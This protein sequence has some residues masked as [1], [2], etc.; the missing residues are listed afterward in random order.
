M[1]F[2]Y[3]CKQKGFPSIDSMERIEVSS[4]IDM[5]FEGT[6]YYYADASGKFVR[7][8]EDR[9]EQLARIVSESTYDEIVNSVEGEYNIILHDKDA[10]VITV[11]GDKLAL[12]DIYY[13][14][15]DDCVILGN[16]LEIF[17]ESKLQL[18]YDQNAFITT[19]LICMPKKQTIYNEI[20]RL[21]YNKYIHLDLDSSEFK[22]GEFE[23]KDIN[24]AD[25]GPDDLDRYVEILENAILSRASDK[26][27]ILSSSGG[28]DSSMMLAILTKHL[29]ADKV[30]AVVFEVKLPDGTIFNKYEIDKVLKISEYL[31]V[32]T[33]ILTVDYDSEEL[34]NLMREVHPMLHTQQLFSMPSNHYPIARFIE[35]KYGKDVTLFNGE[36]CDSL[37]NYGFSQFCSLPHD[38]YDFNEYADKMKT[39]LFGPTFLRKIKD[40]SYKDD[41]V[42]KIFVEQSGKDGFVEVEGRPW[43]EVMQDYLFS[44]ITSDVRLPLRKIEPDFVKKDYLAKYIEHVKTEYFA[45]ISEKI[46]ENNLYYYFAILYMDFHLQSS[47]IRR[48]RAFSKNGRTPF[49]DS[50]LFRYLYRMPESFGRGLNFNAVKYPLK[51]LIKSGKYDYPLEVVRQ[52]PHSYLSETEEINIYDQYVCKGVVSKVFR[53]TIASGEISEVLDENIFDMKMF[54]DPDEEGLD[55]ISYRSLIM[56]FILSYKRSGCRV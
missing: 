3:D 46:N 13:Y 39:Y 51:E 22:I 34:E 53:E 9:M 6:V 30:R 12:K 29:G 28:Y 55:M 43:S 19:V 23:D 27:N 33:D 38:D 45:E 15:D 36:G 37:H 40:G 2:F 26:L 54:K 48:I 35:E 32:Q 18:S 50:N 11:L 16:D 25:Y 56:S 41:V 24:I 1:R 8:G 4:S 14:V 42:F 49:L 31:G 44:F 7:F 10:S 52:G 21:Q 20:K 47:K 5:Y 17:E